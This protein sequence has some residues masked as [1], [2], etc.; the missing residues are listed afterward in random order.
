[1]G[2]RLAPAATAVAISALACVPAPARAAVMETPSAIGT[3]SVLW[4]VAN[5]S[6]EGFRAVLARAP[7]RLARFPLL[8]SAATTLGINDGDIVRAVPLAARGAA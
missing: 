2:R 4:L 5:R 1:M 8:P 6:F 3:E 7:A